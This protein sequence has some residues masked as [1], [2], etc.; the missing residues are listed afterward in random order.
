MKILK[1]ERPALQFVSLA[2]L[3]YEESI[4][5]DYY[6]N[7]TM[8]YRGETHKQ[9]LKQVLVELPSLE[10]TRGQKQRLREVFETIVQR[11]RDGVGGKGLT[12]Q[13]EM[14]VKYLVYL[15]SQTEPEWEVS[16]LK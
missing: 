10:A 13:L 6:K 8:V 1:R 11:N 2:E 5:S 14:K 12:A 3:R 7:Y 9:M 15:L 16:V 4:S